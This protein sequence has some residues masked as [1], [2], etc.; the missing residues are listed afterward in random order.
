MMPVAIALVVLV[1]LGLALFFRIPALVA[2]SFLVA[3]LAVVAWIHQ[4]WS[5]AQGALTIVGLLCL[6]QVSYV[7]GLGLV[8]LARQ[9]WRRWIGHRRRN[10]ARAGPAG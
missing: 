3:I 4:S 9:L 5:F 10:I 1:G 6:L 7:L 8:L 2:A